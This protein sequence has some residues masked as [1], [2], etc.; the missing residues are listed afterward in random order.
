[1]SHNRFLRLALQYLVYSFESQVYYHLSDFAGI[2]LFPR[3][4][5]RL[6]QCVL[7]PQ[8]D[9]AILL[10]FHPRLVEGYRQNLT[11][12]KLSEH[13]FSSDSNSVS[14]FPTQNCIEQYSMQAR[15]VVSLFWENPYDRSLNA[16]Q[17]VFR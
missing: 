7:D 9:H 11:A 6:G 17:K 15:F 5:Y 14:I 4:M 10:E 8:C 12:L 3:F 2:N 13:T 1:M 16:A